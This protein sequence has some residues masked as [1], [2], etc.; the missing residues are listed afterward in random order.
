MGDATLMPRDDWTM[1]LLAD[2]GAYRGDDYPWDMPPSPSGPARIT[3][4]PADSMYPA[5]E[6]PPDQ[7]LPPPENPAR[8][9]PKALLPNLSDPS[10]YGPQP[11]PTMQANDQGKIP[12][13]DPRIMG[14]VADIGNALYNTVPGPGGGA[15]AAAGVGKGIILGIGARTANKAML[16]RAK[17]LALA[18]KTPSEIR[19]ATRWPEGPTGWEQGADQQWG[20]EIPGVNARMRK[21]SGIGYEEVAPLSEHMQYPEL[22]EAMP[23]MANIP[24]TKM[25]P[26]H[27]QYLASQFGAAPSAIGGSYRA[28]TARKPS[29]IF[30]NPRSSFGARS[31]LLHEGSHGVQQRAGFPSG[32]APISPADIAPGMSEWG[33]Y[34]DALRAGADDAT[35]RAHAAFEGYRRQ[36]GED[37][38]RRAQKN[39]DL[40]AAEL[41]ATPLRKMT[42]Y[43]YSKQI[44]SYNDPIVTKKRA[45]GMGGLFEP[46]RTDAIV[47]GRSGRPIKAAPLPIGTEGEILR[48]GYE[49][50]TGPRPPPGVEQPP[51][52]QAMARQAP[53]VE[54]AL[55]Q[56]EPVRTDLPT[57]AYHGTRAVFPEFKY[58]T[59]LNPDEGITTIDAALGPHAA[60]DPA[61][62]SSFVKTVADFSDDPG[63]IAW[64]K[65]AGVK[66]PEQKPH[67]IPL[68]IPAEEKFL[69]AE[70]P[71][72]GGYAQRS[73]LDEHIPLWQ[74][75]AS[76]AHLIARMAAKEAYTREPDLL[77][78]YLQEARNRPAAEALSEARA[79]AAGERV[80][81]HGSEPKTLDEFLKG[82]GG[83]PQNDPDRKAMVDIARKAWQDKGYEGIRYINTAPGE[84]GAPGVKDPT[85]TGYIIFDPRKMRSEFAR[86]DPRMMHS[87]DLMTGVAGAGVM[88]GLA[89]QDQ[90]RQ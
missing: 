8:E 61:I 3:V 58:L 31:V 4:R 89:A 18:G 66:V 38:A 7:L 1:S 52:T 57:P 55:A 36:A 48:Q 39:M 24:T 78:R 73:P 51:F 42:D 9:I 33:I 65:A 64:A 30:Y 11:Q 25:A 60:K 23:E 69:Q 79:L 88:G 5:Q 13:S 37:Q 32:G 35:A 41:L 40:T 70:Q 76:D 68:R 10:T 34:Q 44:I 45:A 80:S 14:G 2:Q 19:R 50:A 26:E 83:V 74:R 67:I 27:V 82:Y 86:F 77:T 85:A 17:E 84:A 54:R 46:L 59:E 12:T 16:N 81:L 56:G 63:Y 87:R 6:P 71:L 90:Y 62:A 47:R 15:A 75:V 72:F 20:F 22:Y 21:N 29:E 28:Y 43:P 53:A 49:R